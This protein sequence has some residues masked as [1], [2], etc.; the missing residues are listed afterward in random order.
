MNSVDQ[1]QCVDYIKRRNNMAGFV[2]KPKE[3]KQE[4]NLESQKE[5]IGINDLN[6]GVPNE[7]DGFAL[8]IIKTE[9]GYKVCKV[10]VYL[11]N[12]EVIHECS[13]KAE[14]QEVFKIQVVKNGIIS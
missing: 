1:V 11:H 3:V 7:P 13:G 8:S 5:L 14:A 12:A 9:A 10:P 4:L 6:R 2:K